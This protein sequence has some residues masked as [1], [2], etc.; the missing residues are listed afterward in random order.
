M[1]LTDEQRLIQRHVREFAQAE[2]EPVAVEHEQA[3]RYPRD[4]IEMAAEADLLAPRLDESVGGAGLGVV[5]SLLL[6]EEFHRAD[7]GI[8]ESVTAVTF[9]C[10]PIIEY[11]TPDLVEEWVRP[12]C[13]GEVVSSVAM[14]EPGA[15]SDFAAIETSA[16]R[17]GDEYV[18]NGDKVFISNGSV[19]DVS[20]VYARTSSPEEP[21]RGLSSFVVPADADGVE[22]TPM[23]GY[24]GPGATDIGQVYLSDVRVPVENRLGD[25]GD[26]FYQA[27]TFL[28]EARLDVAAACVGA[29][30]GAL[31]LVGEYVTEREA[32]GGPI[33]EKQAVR[34][35][36]ADLETRLGGAR[37]LVYE[38]ARDLEREGE[39]DAAR[40]AQAKL[41]ATTLL[42]DVASEAVQLHGGYGLFDEYRVE[43]FFRFSKVP[44]IYEGTNEIMRT[45]VADGML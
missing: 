45:V 41:L 4:L 14:T 38:V 18:L 19:A 27:M 12:A 44:Q 43:T 36:I 15:G 39:V 3:G 34:H 22:Q 21:H 24:M 20:L 25:E 35:R 40:S 13:R 33:A 28:D 16:E 31:D 37:S 30:R 5:S 29:A 11:G 10:E 26:G 32:F 17:D 9:G 1:H 8:G 23:E 2:I 6:N 42:E 7:P